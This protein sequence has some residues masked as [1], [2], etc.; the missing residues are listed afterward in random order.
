M[1]IMKLYEVID[2]SKYLYLVLEYIKGYSL[3]DL[4]KSEKMHYIEQHRALKLFLQIVKGISYCQSKNINH[5]DIKLENIVVIKDD[6]I[7]IIDFGFAVKGNKETYQKLF[8]GTP[9]YMPPEI[10][11]KEKYIAQYSDIWSLGVLLYTMLY[12]RFPFKAKDDETL[13]ELINEAKV[14]FPENISV[15]ENIK[16]LIKKLLNVDPKLRPSPE[17]IINEIIYCDI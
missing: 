15:N 3:L 17:D 2:T 6:I 7:K 8:C 5:R 10:V 1:N 16:A 12:G 13:F 14:K 11:N 9:S 4:I